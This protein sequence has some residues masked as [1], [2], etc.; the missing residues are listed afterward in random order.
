MNRD[1]R[2]LTYEEIKKIYDEMS[3]EDKKMI[4]YITLDLEDNFKKRWRSQL[5]K[6]QPA[7]GQ[8]QS[9]E[10][11]CKVSMFLVERYGSDLKVWELNDEF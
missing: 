2:T 9:L 10:L 3:D 8:K 4:D 7:F 5:H 6:V 11:L 1:D